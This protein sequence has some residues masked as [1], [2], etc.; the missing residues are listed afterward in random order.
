MHVFDRVFRPEATQEQL[1][2]VLEGLVQS[3][4]DGESASIIAY[5][6]SNT[7]KSFTLF[8]DEKRPG[9]LFRSAELFIAIASMDKGSS[10]E[11]SF[12]MIELFNGNITDLFADPRTSNRVSLERSP[13]GFTVSGATSK[14]LSSVEDVERCWQRGCAVRHAT[15]PDVGLHDSRSHLIVFLAVRSAHR[16]TGETTVGQLCLCDLAGSENFE[17]P[18]TGEDQRGSRSIG[19]S[20]A[21]LGDL[22]GTLDEGRKPRFQS[23]K[24][25]ALL[26]ECAGGS[27]KT[28]LIV[29]LSPTE[30]CAGETF[31]TLA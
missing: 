1:F 29:C 18:G 17:R 5:G 15:S 6:P 14:P 21:A 7:G 8:G 28:A 22:L 9:V 3:V 2:N 23:S 26:S 20:L 19:A 25:T 16:F 12:S 11:I 30:G 24:L 4:A 27:S 31:A 10:F 13:R